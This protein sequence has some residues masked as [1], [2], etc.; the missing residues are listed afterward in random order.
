MK[1]T[2]TVLG[3]FAAA[4]TLLLAGCG[5]DTAGTA[6]P[7]TTTSAA[8]SSDMA[9]SSDASSAPSSDA[10]SSDASSSDASSSDATSSED[11]SSSS[12]DTAPTTTVGGESTLDETSTKWFDTYCSGVSPALEEAKKLSSIGGTSDPKALFKTLSSTMTTMGNAF[13]QT[14]QKLEG[15][16]AP[17]FN[18]GDTLAATV[19]KV[20]KE[21]GPKF[22]EL[23][24]ELAKADPSDPKSMEKL[25]TLGSS[26]SD[27]Q[28][29][30][31]F[32]V[33]SKTLAAIKEVPS[34]TPLFSMGG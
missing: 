27:L 34:C 24:T 31:K 22:T 7:A 26:M 6:A 33:D 30:A 18:G 16:P 32:K 23:G 25:S 13:T 5:S 20:M 10:S 1:R 4:A 2:T 29:L 3:A 9:P 28:D 14:A 8:M 11:S 17:T 15:V 21:Y 19:L 12:E